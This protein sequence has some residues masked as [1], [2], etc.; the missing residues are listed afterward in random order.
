MHRAGN[1][2]ASQGAFGEPGILMTAPVPDHREP[3]SGIHYAQLFSPG[4]N[5]FHGTGGNL[6]YFCNFDKIHCLTH[7][8]PRIAFFFQN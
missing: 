6:A 3:A 4:L 2:G 5:M 1:N 8:F 7:L